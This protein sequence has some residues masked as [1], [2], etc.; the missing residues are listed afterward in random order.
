MQGLKPLYELLP[1]KDNL[2]LFKGDFYMV[3]GIFCLRF[4]SLKKENSKNNI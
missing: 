1:L 2:K 3:E 4:H